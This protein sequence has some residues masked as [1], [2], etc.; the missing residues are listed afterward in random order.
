MKSILFR[1]AD[2]YD[3]EDIYYILNNSFARFSILFKPS[4]L[5]VRKNDIHERISDWWVMS[6]NNKDIGCVKAYI[7]EDYFTFCYLAI[8][9]DYQRK[10][11]GK[12]MVKFLMLEAQKKNINVIKI[13]L[14]DSLACNLRFFTEL[15]FLKRIPFNSKGHHIYEIRI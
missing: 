15:G 7:E 11:F 9:E 10:G 13:V 6:L 8:R 3:A 12:K 4:A 2:F 1:P 14:R 5:N